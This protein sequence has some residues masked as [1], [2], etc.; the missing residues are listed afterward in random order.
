M[1]F[2]RLQDLGEDKFRKILNL[3]MRGQSTHSI[4]RMMQ[5]PPPKGWGLF[6]DLAERSLQQQLNRLRIVAAKGAFGT[7]AAEVLTLQGTPQVKMLEGVSTQVIER[8]EEVSTVQRQ[9]MLDVVAREKQTP[10]PVGAYTVTNEVIE[11]YRK[12][13]IDIQ[14][15]RF[16]LG[17]DEYKGPV[18]GGM[19]LRGATQTTMLPDGSNVQKQVFEAVTT[20]E[21][22]FAAR[23]RQLIANE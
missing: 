1:A 6:Q 22:I 3:L 8:L 12:V 20:I 10:V 4:A 13:L 17:L 11:G 7:K 9:R 21:E 16:D 18:G 14:K 15:M 23:N 5:Q 19:V 2:D